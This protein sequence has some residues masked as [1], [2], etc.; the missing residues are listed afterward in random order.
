MLQI[1]SQGRGS[2]DAIRQRR[3][4]SSNQLTI[5]PV[6]PQKTPSNEEIINYYVF[7]KLDYRLYNGSLDDLSMH[8]GIWDQTTST[9]RQALANENRVIANIARIQRDDHVIDLGCGYGTTAVWLALNIGCRVTGITLSTDQVLH[10]RR[11]AQKRGVERLVNFRIMDFHRAQFKDC[12]F[13]AAISIESICHSS[14]KLNALNEA[15]R[16]LKPA[17]RLA[18]ADAYFAK[19]AKTLTQQE[20]QIA[21]TC[22]A[23]VHIPP[24]PEREQFEDW[25]ISAGF[26]KIDWRDKTHCILP[27]AKRVNRLGRILLPISRVLST[28]GVRSLQKTHMEAF[29]SQYDAF[30]SGLGVY[31]IFLAVKPPTAGSRAHS[32][33]QSLQYA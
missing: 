1:L 18:I 19:R 3:R 10:A 6:F 23:G 21:E 31:G 7:S 12:M 15:W 4:N 9:H 26:T 28:F 33:D 30:R 13:D 11:L 2:A 5:F 14:K 17:G 32:V 29:I 22:F 25:L 20:R 27:T 8:Y 24:L 16:I